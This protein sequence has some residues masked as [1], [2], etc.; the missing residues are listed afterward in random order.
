MQSCDD[1][2]FSF[3]R[4]IDVTQNFVV[5]KF[6]VGKFGILEIYLILLNQTI[7]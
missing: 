7:K 5:G 1:A 6:H 3:Q 2:Q 4:I